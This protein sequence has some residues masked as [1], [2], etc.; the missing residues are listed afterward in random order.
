MR[1]AKTKN[2]LVS[3]CERGGERMLPRGKIKYQVRER[4][5][6]RDSKARRQT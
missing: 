2:K 4:E 6:E 1:S 3:G 5:R